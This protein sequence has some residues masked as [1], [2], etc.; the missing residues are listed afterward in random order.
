MSDT[1]RSELLGRSLDDKAVLRHE[2]RRLPVE[3]KMKVI[4]LMQRRANEIRRATGRPVRPEWSWDVVG[5]TGS[6][7]PPR[8]GSLLARLGIYEHVQAEQRISAEFD[9]LHTSLADNH[10]GVSALLDVYSDA[11]A[12]VAAVN[13]YLTSFNELEP[14]YQNL[15]TSGITEG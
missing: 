2:L 13:S 12:A 11:S 10:P 5:I 14:V 4:A 9:E 7:P 8:A 15:T 1:N 6:S 3:D